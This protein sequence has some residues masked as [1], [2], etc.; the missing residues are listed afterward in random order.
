MKFILAPKS[1][2]LGLAFIAFFNINSIAQVGIGTVTPQGSLDIESTTQGVVLPR[3]VLTRTD[4]QSPVTNPQTGAIVSGTV[5]YNTNTTIDGN[6]SVYPGIYVWIVDKWVPQFSQ[7]QSILIRQVGT[8]FRT[9]SDLGFQNIPLTATTFTPEYSGTYKI[10]LSVN[11]GG[12]V[13]RRPG[14]DGL[15]TG[16][17]TGRF[18]LRYNNGSDVDYFIPIKSFSSRY[19][20]GSSYFA[21]WKQQSIVFYVVINRGDTPTFELRVDQLPSPE[22][23][24]SGGNNG[25]GRGNVGDDI[26][27]TIE[28][29]FVGGA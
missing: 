27:C 15:N 3:V 11:Y 13:M 24:G 10:E 7:K 9:E 6:F 2:Y 17:H 8:D 12:G 1:I 23:T 21:I 28:I 20:T 19:R 4:T 18:R 26:P 5:V 16:Y 22:F 14:N 29:D 25:T